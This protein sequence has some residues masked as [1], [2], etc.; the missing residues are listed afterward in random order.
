VDD[1]ATRGNAIVRRVAVE[2]P[3]RRLDLV[4]RPGAG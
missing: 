1:G 3:R 2:A 4:D